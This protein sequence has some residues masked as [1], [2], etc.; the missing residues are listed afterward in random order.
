[1]QKHTPSSDDHVRS[2]VEQA[3]VAV[4]QGLDAEQLQEYLSSVIGRVR[5]DGAVA[6][7][8]LVGGAGSGKSTLARA[9]VA[10]LARQGLAA[11]TIST[12]DYNRGDRKWRWE[13]FEGAGGNQVRDPMGKWDFDFM[14]QKIDAIR[15]NRDPHRTVKVPTY[16]Q[17]TGVAIAEGEAHYKHAVPMVDV[18]IVEGDMARVRDPDLRIYLHAPDA[19]RLQNRLARDL[20]HRNTNGEDE[21][22]V[23]DNFALRHRNQ[24]VPYTLPAAAQADVLAVIMPESSGDWR[25]NVYEK[26]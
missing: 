10:F 23:R 16:N 3:Y 8:S 24:H 12:D 4:R 22:K 20:Q 13:Q 15:A 11:D 18:L 26:Q 25:F 7:V 1:M 5:R 9:L 2:L 14:N 6:V 19:L 17:T 21:Q